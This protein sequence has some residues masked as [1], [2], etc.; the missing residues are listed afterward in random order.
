MVVPEVY[1]DVGRRAEV[2]TRSQIERGRMLNFAVQS[3]FVWAVT[4][5]KVSVALFLL[6]I[7]PS[8]PY[9]LFLYGMMAFLWMY[10]AIICAATLTQCRP[11]N[12]AW[13]VDFEE[14]KCLIPASLRGLDYSNNCLCLVTDI[15]LALLPIPMLWHVQLRR[16]VK[17]VIIAILS[18]GVLSV[19]PAPFPDSQRQ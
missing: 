17:A 19:L 1:A 4:F 5:V 12:N 13:R 8:R 7:A 3:V 10:T 2:L 6:R 9:R 15:V 11:L 18:L 14:E 16:K